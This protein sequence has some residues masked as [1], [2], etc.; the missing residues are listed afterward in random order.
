MGEGLYGPT[1]IR[2]PFPRIPYDNETEICMAG[3]WDLAWNGWLPQRPRYNEASFVS[4]NDRRRYYNGS[5]LRPEK[6]NA[7]RAQL[8]SFVED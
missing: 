8:C 7:E 6:V 4:R 1:R 5:N 2:T 3:M